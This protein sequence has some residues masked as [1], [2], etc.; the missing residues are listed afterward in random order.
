MKN[1][2]II[3]IAIIAGVWVSAW[4]LM[5]NKS[6]PQDNTITT[7]QAE[8]QQEEMRIV[9]VDA[10]RFE[11]IPSTIRVQQGEKVA[12]K[13]NDLD[14]RH[15]AFFPSLKTTQDKAWNFIIDTS[16]PWTYEFRCANMCG[17]WHPNMKWTLVIEPADEISD[18]EIIKLSHNGRQLIPSEVTLKAWKDYTFE[19]TP[20][21]NGIGCMSTIKREWTTISDSQLV[22]A[23]ETILFAMKNAEVGTYKFVCNGMGMEQ[24]KVVIEA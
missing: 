8:G 17:S 11:Y 18:I 13:I 2:I 24:G 6:I 21:S 4:A 7:I 22:L 1:N 16:T 19:I 12:L 23:N 20:E 9:T 5:N 3:T 14:T 10:K 15:S